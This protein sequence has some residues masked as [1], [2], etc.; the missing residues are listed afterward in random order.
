M[1]SLIVIRPALRD[2]LQ[3]GFERG[4]GTLAGIVAAALIIAATSHSPWVLAAGVTVFA[5][6]SYALF[7]VDYAWFAVTLTAYVVFLLSLAGIHEKPLIMHRV[8]FTLCG[9]GVALLTHLAVNYLLRSR[10][11]NLESP[12]K[13]S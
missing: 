7:Q 12:R 13:A 11:E 2:S 1:T 8:L 4:L 9:I 10:Q 6:G 5:W 3:R